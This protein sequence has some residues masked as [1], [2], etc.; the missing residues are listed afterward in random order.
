[1]S[2][3]DCSIVFA[4]FEN[5]QCVLGGGGEIRHQGTTGEQ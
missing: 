1:M 3:C 2:R 4:K 5:Q